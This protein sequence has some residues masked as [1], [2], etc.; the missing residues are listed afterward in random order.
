MKK[1]KAFGLIILST[2]ALA[3]CVT[4]NPNY[5]PTAPVSSTNVM[6]V[7]DTSSFSN[8]VNKLQSGITAT[9]PVDPYAGL[10]QALLGG[11]AAVVTGASLVVAKVKNSQA[12]TANAAATHLATVLPDNMVAQAVNSA[13][14]PAI[15]SAVS[16]HLAAAPNTSQVA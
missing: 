4:K 1:I 14:T 15:A 8:V 9:A 12:N 7:P 11:V 13:P 2:I 10:L 3:G 16:A 6:Y 5:I